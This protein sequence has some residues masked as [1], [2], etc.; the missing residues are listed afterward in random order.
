VPLES[1]RG[2]LCRVAHAHGYCGPGWLADLAGIPPGGLER[3]DRATPLAH[4]LRLEVSE[5]L[6]MCYRPVKGKERFERRSFL[7]VLIG[8]HQLNYRHPRICPCCMRD[9]SVWWAVWDLALVSACPIHR[10]LLIDLCP[11][12][13]RKLTWHRRAVHECRCGADLRKAEPAT[14]DGN[15]VTINAAIYRAAGFYQKACEEELQRA[16]FPPVLGDLK[17]D[18]LLRLVRFVGSIQEQGKLRRK[19]IRFAPT[20]LD[21]AIQVGTAAASILMD[22]PRSFREM[23]RRM[24]PGQIKSAADLSFYDVFGNFYRHLYAVLPRKEFGFLHDAFEEFVVQD[25]K[26]LVRGQHRFFPN[27]TRRNSQWMPAQEAETTM[28]MTSKRLGALVRNRELE[29]IFVKTGRHRTECW[30][31]RESLSRWAAKREAELA[32][33]MSRPEAKG[34]LGLGHDTLLTVAQAGLIRYVS[35]SEKFS[36]TNGVYFLREDVLRIKHAFEKHAVPVQPYSRPGE[37]IAL[38]HGLRNYLGRDSGFPAAIRAVL[39]SK[40]AP[41]GSTKSFPGITGYLF[42]SEDLRK[43]R[44]VRTE[45]SPEDFLNFKEAASALGTRTAVIHGL[46][47]RGI[48]S[49]P[50]EYRPGL[51][52]L[53]PAGEVRRFAQHYVDATVVA[54]RSNATIHWVKRCLRESAVP[55]LEISVPGKG[56]KLFLR[57]ELAAKV[58]IPQRRT[59]REWRRLT[60]AVASDK[61]SCQTKS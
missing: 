7:G 4:V 14:A 49:T 17:L 55:I 54:Q 6:R 28:H 34:A 37:L 15:L 57:R 35:G 26:G 58:Q 31:R 10:C 19:Q 51:S 50:N 44:H 18:A 16:S 33:Y 42:P 32:R 2:Y 13:G 3:E 8:A 40:L 53:V 46:V 29:G 5:W 48:L 27:L 41:V 23:L 25:W 20:D 30:I 11:A 39:D 52:K 61:Y 22:W 43:Y 1:P 38:R 36:R 45:L 59:P 60:G 12:C 47:V 21:T 24:V 9:H 56:Q